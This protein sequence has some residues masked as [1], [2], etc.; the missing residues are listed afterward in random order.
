MHRLAVGA[1]IVVLASGL[2]QA[3]PA[4]PTRTVTAIVGFSAGGSVDVMARHLLGVI[5]AQLIAPAVRGS[6]MTG[7]FAVFCLAAAAR[8][9]MPG[10]FR[11]VADQPPK[12]SFCHIAGAGIGLVSGFAGVG[13]GILTNIVMAVSGMSMHKSIGRAAAV[14]RD[15]DAVVE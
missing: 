11:P 4:Y 1:A 10:W 14:G 6:V 13:G 15:H 3:Q 7:V 2:A 8:F 5:S 9:A 12:G